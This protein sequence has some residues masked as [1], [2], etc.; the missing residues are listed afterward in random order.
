M[1]KFHFLLAF[2]LLISALAFQVSAT[3]ETPRVHA[4]RHCVCG[5][6]AVDVEEH[7]CNNLPWKSLPAGTTDLSQLANGNYYLT[8]D[9]TVTEAPKTGENSPWKDKKI[10]LCLNGY[11]I[12]TTAGSV[13]GYVDQAT[14]NICDCTGQKDS[15]GLWH[16]DGTVTA[17]REGKTLSYGGVCNL[18]A[19]TL[20]NVYGGNFVGAT[21]AHAGG[22]F[23]VCHDGF[24]ANGLTYASNKDPGLFTRLTV[25][26]GHFSGGQVVQ[27][28]KQ[29]HGNGGLI[30]AWHNADV[31]IYGGTFTGG[32]AYVGGNLYL[33][34]TGDNVIKNCTITNGTAVQEC[35]NFHAPKTTVDM[36]NTYISGGS[37]EVAQV[38]KD[39]KYQKSY[40][41]LADAIAAVQDQS[42][43]YVQLLQDAETDLTLSGTVYL[44]LNGCDLSGVTITGTV[45]GMDASTNSYYGGNAGILTPASGVPQRFV[46]TAA[47]QTGNPLR[48]LRVEE[49][50]G[51]SFH[52]FY[53]G[54]TD[55][56]LSPARSGLG[57]KATF[58]GDAQVKSQ[59]A[60]DRAFGMA[61]SLTPVPDS[62]DSDVVRAL[63]SR[64][65]QSGTP[66]SKRLVIYDI[67]DPEATN[68]NARAETEIYGKAFLRLSDG[69]VLYSEQAHKNLREIVETVNDN[70]DSFT[71]AQ[72]NAVDAM[73]KAHEPYMSGWH[74]GNIHHHDTAKWKPWPEDNKWVSG[75]HYYLTHDLTDIKGITVAEGKTL[76]ICLNGFDIQSSTASTRLLQIKGQLTIHDH[77]DENGDYAGDIVTNHTG[78]V[79]GPLFYVYENAVFNLYGGNLKAAEGTVASRGGVGM[80]GNGS[81]KPNAVMNIYNGTVSGGSVEA[82]WD[83][84]EGNFVDKTGCGYGGNIEMI[85][86]SVLNIYDGRI[87]GGKTMYATVDGTVVTSKN[88][89]LGG[90]LC[91]GANS[92]VNMYSGS[93][94]GGYVESASAGTGLGGNIYNPG[95]TLNLLGGSVTDG[96]AKGGRGGNIFTTGAITL[97]NMTVTGGS[98][99]A[100]TGEPNSGLGSGIY[101]TK[102]IDLA[103]KTRIENNGDQ[104]IYLAEKASLDGAALTAGS[105][106]GVTGQLHGRVST[107][108]ATVSYFFSNDSDYTVAR[109]N[110]GVALVPRGVD[111]GLVDTQP[112][113]FSVGYSMT[114]ISPVE[115]GLIMSSYGNP[116]GRKSSGLAYRLYATTVAVTDEDNNTFLM[117][118]ADLQNSPVELFQEAFN[119][120]SEVTGVPAENIYVSCT[121]THNVPTL[122]TSSAGNKRYLYQFMDALISGALTAMADRAPATM[123]TG[124]FDTQ[125][126][127]YTR[128]YYYPDANGQ[129]TDA[130]GNPISYFGD[131]FGNQPKDNSIIKRVEEGDHTMHLLAFQRTGKDPILLANWRAHPHR[132]GGMESYVV[133]ADVIGALREYIHANTDYRFAYFQGA[134]GNMNTTSRITGETYE[135]GKVKEYGDELGRQIVKNG[136]PTLKSAATGKVQTTKVIYAAPVD[137]SEDDRY[138]EAVELSNYYKNNPDLMDTYAE[139]VAK[140]NS[141]GFSS[142]F[143]AQRLI[144]KY[145]MDLTCDLELNIFSIGDS[146]GF[147]TGPGEF[148]SS[149]SE[150]METRSPFKTTFCLGYSNGNVAY[151]PYKIS[152]YSSYEYHYCLF[153]QDT[154]VE[155]MMAIYEE[156]LKRFYNAAP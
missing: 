147:Y 132:S 56:V 14:I 103:G 129:Y 6:S 151:L 29:Q 112:A 117:I 75:G 133:T 139:Q 5:G 138:E 86:Y 39:G 10:N 136:L 58:A 131:Q 150:E 135:K 45:Y 15:N 93:I 37:P 51:Y 97:K 12:H 52:R 35:G 77:C 111:T 20:V 89:G 68:N 153:E 106:V 1:K 114:D 134:A 82:R 16:W 24:S 128:H 22:I 47:G 126:M 33:S 4:G 25:Y 144:K 23:N 21:G 13:F 119:R 102:H 113:S 94:S 116:N 32:S 7:T 76:D 142:V 73:V 9:I 31:H 50:K 44:D 125:G 34:S 154:A 90:N 49:E 115:E 65:Y 36:T 91:M 156:N 140:A 74:I 61:V 19:N 96:T 104:D 124:S 101:A 78:Y 155:T 70:W 64:Y 8:G 98:A 100:R 3:E 79:M 121:H 120:I 42:N 59:L 55:A 87:F 38:V 53:I 141:M 83:S 99:T 46:K 66:F 84:A 43:M 109:A 63:G 62:L 54:I 17:N 105:R 146:V 122:T 26:N 27:N 41:N 149:V 2:L 81:Q 108:P 107:N 57:L 18:R 80:V 11:D 60:E 152:H 88:S 137:H 148:W 71:K 110:G 40:L 30:N 28:A 95:G 118:T 143:H 72:K 67:L 123:Q 69:T 92:T 127:N 85:S 145:G 130:N 48:Y